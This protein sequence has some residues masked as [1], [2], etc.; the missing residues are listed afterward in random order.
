M[1][2][3][4]KKSIFLLTESFINPHFTERSLANL[5]MPYNVTLPSPAQ[6]TPHIYVST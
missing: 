6:S 3:K 1:F 2:W 4:K 5:H